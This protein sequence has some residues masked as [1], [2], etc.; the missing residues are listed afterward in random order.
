VWVENDRGLAELKRKDRDFT[1]QDKAILFAAQAER[2]RSVIPKY[3]ELAERGQAE[4]TFS[5][6]Y[7][8]ILPLICHVDSAR[9]ANPQIQL[10]ERHFSH[11]E[12]AELQIELGMGLFERMLGRRPKGMWPSEMAVGEAVIGL[13]EKAKLDW[14][15]SDE[16]GNL[17]FRAVIALDGENA[18]EFY[19]RDGHDV[20]N[21]LYTELESSAD[22]VTTTVSDF[23]AE[24]PPL[25]QLHHLH[26]GSWIGASLDTWIGDP[27]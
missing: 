3:R 12:D 13:T 26:T 25:Q 7:H 8:P 21:A 4:L 6:Y 1:E 14:M 23:L 20:L 27:E 11:R 9:S 24:H 18:W 5:P 15:I 2:I 22:V 17:D 10:P 16:E 19:P